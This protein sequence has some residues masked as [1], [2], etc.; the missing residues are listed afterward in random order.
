MIDIRVG[1]CY[2][3]S[4]NIPSDMML[5]YMINYYDESW[6]NY[7]RNREGERIKVTRYYERDGT[8][9]VEATGFSYII[10]IDCLA[11]YHDNFNPDEG[12]NFFE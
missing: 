5:K 8:P 7:L 6:I 10:P 12:V 2:T 4:D 9:F 1:E 11:E 3:I